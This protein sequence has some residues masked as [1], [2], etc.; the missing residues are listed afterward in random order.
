MSVYLSLFFCIKDKAL[1]SL[2]ELLK[3]HLKINSFLQYSILILHS[4]PD[5]LERSFLWLV[6]I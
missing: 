1:E 2:F 5:N 3:T 6:N 4:G